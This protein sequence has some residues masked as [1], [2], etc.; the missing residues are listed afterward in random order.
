MADDDTSEIGPISGPPPEPDASA[1]PPTETEEAPQA[2]PSTQADVDEDKKQMAT[3]EQ[4]MDAINQRLNDME[5]QRGQ[6]EERWKTQVQPY[7]EAVTREINAPIPP[8]PQLQGDPPPPP[9]QEQ[10]GNGAEAVVNAFK[11]LTLLGMAYGISARR[12]GT[13]R[14]A[15]LAGAIEGFADAV[16]NNS[17]QGKKQ[18]QAAYALWEKQREFDRD[19]RKMQLDN[20]H[21]ILQ[22]QH[23]SLDNKL[24]L[25]GML[26]KEKSDYKTQEAAERQDL[27]ALQKELRTKYEIHQKA[28]QQHEKDRPKVQ[29]M[30]GKTGEHL[31]YYTWLRN[32]F[33]V[34]LHPNDPQEKYDALPENQQYSAYNDELAQKKL[35]EDLAK[36][37]AEIPI[38]AEKARAVQEA[39]DKQK[40]AD[41]DE[42]K[43][44][45]ADNPLG[46]NLGQ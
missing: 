42:G 23:L 38:E 16:H 11:F 33:G 30:I 6:W 45:S 10:H 1:D 22:E 18:S 4:G 40:K 29:G 34:E 19:E 26:A 13:V 3:A 28:E 2:P 44:S 15:A 43:G 35:D 7:V 12:G 20:Y 21:A 37:K 8:P 36:R 24:K 27:I 14:K 32:K 46:L 5:K 17:E 9:T 25:I 39:R 41:E 31:G